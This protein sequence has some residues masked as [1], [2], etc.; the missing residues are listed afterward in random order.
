MDYVDYDYYQNS[1]KGFTT[2]S[3]KFPYYSERAYEKVDAMTQT[4]TDEIKASDSFKKCL[5]A[6]TDILYKEENEQEV[7]S[8]KVGPYTRQFR[9]KK[10]TIVN[11]QIS[12]KLAIY[13]F[14]TG[15]CYR[16]VFDVY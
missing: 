15:I 13:L 14:D 6:V 16:G 7:S 10:V 8:E 4:L 2:P 3:E 9:E 12:E 1:Y 5:C 11:N